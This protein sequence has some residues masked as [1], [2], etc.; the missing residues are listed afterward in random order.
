MKFDWEGIFLNGLDWQQS[1]EIGLR[2][3]IMFLLVLTFLRL[4]GKKGVRQ[5]SIFEVAIIIALGSAAGDPML[6][7]DYPILPSLL[8]FTVI[9]VLYRIITYYAGKN[10]NFESLVEGDPMYIIEDGQ[11]VMVSRTSHNFAKDE[12]LA[13]LRNEG[14][15]H[16]GQVETAIL[17]TN[18]K[19]S[20]FFYP[21][22]KVKP[23]LPV[24][25]KLYNKKSEDI[26]NQGI[27]ACTNC[28]NCEELAQSSKCSRCGQKEWVPAI[29]KLRIT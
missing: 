4:S 5:L 11:F 17:E 22:D 9:I 25:P 18:G 21:D 7:N 26:T 28:G 1:L 24:L 23:G 3:L 6:S 8:V 19:L 20:I 2:T 29:D 15:S 16:I 14:V 10:E 12:F 13:E 27:Y